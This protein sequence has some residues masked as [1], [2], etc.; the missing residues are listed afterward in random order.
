[1]SEK[2]PELWTPADF[3]AYAQLSINQVAKLRRSGKGPAFIKLGKH[4][5]YVPGVCHRWILANQRTST[6]PADRKVA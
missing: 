2:L 1:M 6:A 3:A 5:R 4:V